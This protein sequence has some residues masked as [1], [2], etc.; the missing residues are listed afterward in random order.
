MKLDSKLPKL[1]ILQEVESYIKEAG[2][3]IIDQ[4]F[5]RPWG[6][7][8]VLDETQ[9]AKFI[10]QYFPQLSIDDIQ[11]TQKLSPKFLVV[12]P[13]QRLSW[14]YHFRR[15]E[16]WTVVH[17]PI[18]VAISATDEQGEYQTY[19]AQEV[20]ELPTGT[21]HRLIGLDQWG[22]VAE[23]WQHTDVSNPSDESDIVRLQDDFGR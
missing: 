4:D 18:A 7:F 8:F 21:R 15:A 23:I 14:Q 13:H 2:Y 5:S 12:A 11:I 16:I 6:G 22:L 17:G 19:Q 10:A 3:H 9:V 1:T 20:I